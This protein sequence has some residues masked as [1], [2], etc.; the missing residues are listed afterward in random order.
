M[1]NLADFLSIYSHRMDLNK[2]SIDA[3]CKWKQILIKTKPCMSTTMLKPMYLIKKVKSIKI[4]T[5][6]QHVQMLE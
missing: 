6:V 1:M 3:E 4:K 5:T 2:L